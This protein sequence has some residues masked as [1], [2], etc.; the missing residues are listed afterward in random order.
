MFNQL[1]RLTMQRSSIIA[2]LIWLS[3]LTLSLLYLFS[4]LRVVSDVTQFMPDNHKNKDVQLLLNELQQGKTARLLILRLSGEDAKTLASLSKQLKSKLDKSK[5]VSLIHNGQQD[6]TPKEFLKGQYKLLYQYRYL[7]SANT[8][9]TEKDLSNALNN[10]LSELRSG[11]NIFKDT[12]ASDPQN[13]FINYL[14]KLS[15]RSSNTHH[16]GVWFNKEK[17][18]AYSQT[19]L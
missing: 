11:I 3:L 5:L 4:S 1:T 8:S 17:T 6:I 2:H 9:L 10:R 7:L 16:H 18:A 13:H 19:V 15:E 12:L 14:L